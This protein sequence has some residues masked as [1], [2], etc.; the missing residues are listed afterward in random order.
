MSILTL[1]CAAVALDVNLINLLAVALEQLRP[2]QLEGGRHAIVLHGKG[3][4]VVVQV[5]LQLESHV[6][7]RVESP[8][9]YLHADMPSIAAH[10]PLVSPR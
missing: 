10:Y 9:S 5:A 7:V 1:G 3:L 4:V 6:Y 2:A 8:G